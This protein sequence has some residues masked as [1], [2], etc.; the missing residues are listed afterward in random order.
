MSSKGLHDRMDSR[1]DPGSGSGP[2]LDRV[3][4][5]RPLSRTPDT[6]CPPGSRYIRAE[7]P[8]SADR[9]RPTCSD[10]QPHTMTPRMILLLCSLVLLV[11]ADLDN[12]DSSLQSTST[13]KD[14]T[15]DEARTAPAANQVYGTDAAARST[16]DEGEEGP[17]SDEAGGKPRSA[18]QPPAV[19]PPAQPRPP[20]PLP[21]VLPLL[22]LSLLPLSALPP[23]AAPEA[24]APQAPVPQ[25]PAPQ[26]PVVQA[27]APQPVA[28]QARSAPLRTRSSSKRRS[29]THRHQ[30]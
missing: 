23:A 21:P 3:W 5:G 15:S 26:V 6:R 13:D 22:P 9:E 25:V 2:G 20:Q 12:S 16:E 17:D 11:E 19:K 27:P 8:P 18:K 29:R 28:P 4:T 24:P 10:L 30:M 1:V 7:Q 14:S